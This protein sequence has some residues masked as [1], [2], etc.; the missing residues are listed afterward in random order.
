MPNTL[1]QLNDFSNSALTYEDQ[2]SY[3][4][5]FSPNSPSNPS[6][7]VN[8][9][10]AFEN[11]VGTNIVEI[12]SAPGPLTYNINLS[13]LA[14]NTSLTWPS[15]PVGVSI[16]NPGGNVYSLTGYFSPET[17]NQIRNPM[18]FVKDQGTNFSYTANIQYP[19]PANVA[20][21]AVKSWTVNA[22]VTA[23]EELSN[24]TAWSYVSND[25][26]TVVGAPQI[27]DAYS[28]PGSYTITVTPSV[29]AAVNILS[30]EGTGGNVSF[31]P[32][33]K[34]LT[35]TGD[36][37][38]V[39]NRLSAI[40]FTPATDSIQSLVLTYTLVNPISG[41]STSKTQNITALGAAFN[42]GLTSYVED[43]GADLQY[44]VVD[45]SATATS[46]TIQ[47]A[48][49]VPDRKGYFHLN[50]SNV[51]NTVTWS[52]T[53][54]QVNAA[55]VWYFP[56]V[57]WEDNISL[58]VN[59]SKID[60]G[61][62]QIQHTNQ[63]W[64]LTN[65]AT[66]AEI[67]NMINRT[68]VANT[69]ANIF[70]TSTPTI[71]DG[72]D[73]GQTYTITLSSPVGRFGN[74][75]ANAAA[76]SSYSFTGNR[77]QVNS[78]LA[79]IKFVNNVG[80]SSQTSNFTYTQSRSGFQQVNVSPTLTITPGSIGNTYT[81]TITSDTT[82][83]PTIEQVMFGNIQ[84][85]TVGGGGAGGRSLN[86]PRIGGGGGGGGGAFYVNAVRG[87]ANAL[88]NSTYS[89]TIGIG[90]ADIRGRAGGNTFLTLNSTNYFVAPG[91]G[92][93][94]DN[95]KGGDSSFNGT[96]RTGGNGAKNDRNDAG[97]GGGA[98]P[99][100]GGGFATNFQ[101]T[102][103]AGDGADGYLSTLTGVP[104]YY[105]AGGGGGVFDATGTPNPVPGTGGLGGG[106][107]GAG[108]GGGGS[109]TSGTGF[110]AGGG[111]GGSSFGDGYQG[112]VIIKIS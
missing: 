56:P 27:L 6:V 17:W 98:S 92:S 100:G 51:G 80:V 82:F 62:I 96:V 109:P 44:S 25:T 8:E 74:S 72:P 111:G 40:R 50:G 49:S 52:G 30:S 36:K 69:V 79:N 58:S 3:S 4:I 54:T 67:V 5:A 71:Q 7:A 39:N 73:V 64:V 47:V 68:I 10:F 94:I 53:K 18:I 38:Q 35:I 24:P 76:E 86:T 77:T 91:G 12:S 104:V 48:Q 85:L 55:N 107:N 26:G 31:D 20:N 33:T 15:L 112:V 110:G 106:G 42:I 97:G 89:I 1:T 108:V 34:V 101:P 57:D 2:R 45:L 61:N 103:S 78:E 43:T 59:Q 88:T 95:G 46:F 99:A 32:V 81:A 90:G 105:G 63:P 37:A 21:V 19:D 75:A 13:S 66:N 14:A 28:G 83:T 23:S 22:V 65:S 87:T 102:L 29:A 11:P 16:L 70:A 41:L 84:I 9:D 93:I 60:N